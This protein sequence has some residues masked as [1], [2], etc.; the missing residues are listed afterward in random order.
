MQPFQVQPDA[1]LVLTGTAITLFLKGIVLSY[2]QVRIRVR[3]R[4]FERAEDARLMG[5]PPRSEPELVGRVAAAWRNELEST[6][7]FL[8]LATGYVLIGAS[9]W[10]LLLSAAAYVT[11]RLLQAYSQIRGLQPH[12]TIG[13][14]VGLVAS[15]GLAT[16]LGAQMWS[17]LS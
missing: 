6:P 3:G 8:A 12:R 17:V 11:G 9:G 1:T 15:A 10:P 4:T 5:L 2:L 14:L 16:M 13:Y 7:A